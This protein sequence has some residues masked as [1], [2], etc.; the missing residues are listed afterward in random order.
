MNKIYHAILIF[1]S[2]LPFGILYLIADFF[3]TL[4]YYFIGY[5]R[6]TIKSN[7]RASFPKKSKKELA[8]IQRDFYKNFADYI[9]ETIKLF[10]LSKEQ[11]AKVHTFS[12][13]QVLYESKKNK[14]NVILLAGHFFN[15]EY[16]IGTGN[17]LP[18]KNKYAIFQKVNNPF[19][20]KKINE[21]R[22]RFGTI[23]VEFYDVGKH[24]MRI[25][26]D[27]ENI[28]LFIADQ[29]PYRAHIHHE[30]EFLNQETP[31]FIGYDKVARRKDFDVIYMKTTK[32]K[33]NHYHTEFIKINPNAEK[34]EEY[35]IVDKFFSLLEE[36][37]QQQ[38]AL[39]LWSHKR[40]K[41]K[42]GRDY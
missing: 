32:L 15:W 41:Y 2:K 39:W 6:G 9:V 26:Q 40:W 37:I 33:R 38:P 16:H 11:L 8:K 34:F 12:N 10:S 35:E 19:W 18:Q 42:K 17:I 22:S 13:E 4:N 24:I 30:L 7:L 21:L 28:Y 36:N 25:P 23:P 3:F 27:G 5:R 14:K 29:S 31:V 20:N 1:F